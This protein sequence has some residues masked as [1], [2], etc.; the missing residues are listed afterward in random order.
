M[1]DKEYKN[2]MNFDTKKKIKFIKINCST[3]NN[4]KYYYTD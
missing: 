4:I 1:S 2:A 3:L